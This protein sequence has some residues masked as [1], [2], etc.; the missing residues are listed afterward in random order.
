MLTLGETVVAMQAKIERLQAVNAELRLVIGQAYAELAPFDYK[1]LDMP[2][3]WH[4]R[5][6]DR[7]SFKRDTITHT[8]GCLWKACEAALARPPH[9]DS[10]FPENKP[11]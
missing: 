3:M 10:P 9:G 7:E 5:S 6:C 11:A 8:S 1:Q 2:N 4:C